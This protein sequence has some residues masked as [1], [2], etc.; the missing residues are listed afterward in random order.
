M[1]RHIL[2]C[3]GMKIYFY[4]CYNKIYDLSEKH[5]KEVNDFNDLGSG[6]YRL[7][8]YTSYGTIYSGIFG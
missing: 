5:Y 7:C 1:K 4:L 3:F 8:I 2:N 6:K